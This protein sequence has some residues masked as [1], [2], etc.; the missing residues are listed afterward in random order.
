MTSAVR[1]QPEL[2]WRRR[3]IAAIAGATLSTLATALNHFG[4][5]FLIPAILVAVAA[6]EAILPNIALHYLAFGVFAFRKTFAVFGN[7]TGETKL[8]MAEF[9]LVIYAVVWLA[10]LLKHHRMPLPARW[11]SFTPYLLLGLILTVAGMIQH[12][13]AALRQPMMAYYSLFALLVAWR[14]RERDELKLFALLLLAASFLGQIVDLTVAIGSSVK[15]EMVY[16]N[17]TFVALFFTVRKQFP[18]LRSTA[19]LILLIIPAAHAFFFFRLS[20]L[21]ALL[22]VVVLLL[23]F[24]ASALLAKKKSIRPSK[25]GLA[26]AVIIII[27]GVSVYFLAREKV[28]EIGGELSAVLDLADSMKDL[29]G[30]I[31]SYTSLNQPETNENSSAEKQKANN[32]I[33]LVMWRDAIAEGMKSPLFGIGFGSM[34][35]VEVLKESPKHY[36]YKKDPHN[37]LVS[38]FLHMGLIGLAALLLIIF[39]PV[40]SALKTCADRSSDARDLLLAFT[41]AWTGMTAL[42]LLNVILGTH[43]GAL[44][45]WLLFGLMISTCESI[46]SSPQVI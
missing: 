13:T 2:A 38:T 32:L 45:F 18:V 30:Q 5:W 44:C 3:V 6:L 22:A 23:W 41:A 7:P 28:E 14:I 43:A 25:A 17:V 1:L 46:K 10:D 12:G 24:G 20:V 36:V 21:I 29:D 34:L 37:F 9:I 19:C 8:P 33:R 15:P 11:K 27:V 16:S 26:V 39:P 31:E 4:F 42:A 35:E 40:V